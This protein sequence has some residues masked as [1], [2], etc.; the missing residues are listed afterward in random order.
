MNKWDTAT[1]VRVQGPGN[2]KRN[3]VKGHGTNFRKESGGLGE[4]GHGVEING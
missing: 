4:G 2:H 1:R 3:Q